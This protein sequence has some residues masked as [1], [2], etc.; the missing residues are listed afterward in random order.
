MPWTTPTTPLN[1]PV[2]TMTWRQELPSGETCCGDALFV[3]IDREDGALHLLLLDVMGHGAPAAITVGFVGSLLGQPSFQNRNPADLLDRL[4][5]RL[6][7]HWALTSRHVEGVAVLLDTPSGSMRAGRAGGLRDLWLGRPGLPWA[8][9]QVEGQTFLGIPHEFPYVEIAF[10]Y[11]EDAW[12]V[13]V[14]D[15]VTETGKPGPLFGKG[16]LQRFLAGLSST[17][18]PEDLLNLL[19][20][21]LQHHGGASWPDDDATALVL[22]PARKKIGPG[23]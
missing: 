2:A 9:R 4:H 17:A 18:S 6:Q 10:S 14:T 7:P 23:P 5:G 22:C 19:W 21:S 3:E 8:P 15:G 1:D 16:P 12:L 11:S 13:A 20:R